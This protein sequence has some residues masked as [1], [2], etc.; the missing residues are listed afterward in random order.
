MEFCPNLNDLMFAKQ[1]RGEPRD[2]GTIVVFVDAGR[3]KAMIKC[4]TEGQVGFLTLDTVRG[5]VQTLETALVEGRIDW[6]PDKKQ[7]RGGVKS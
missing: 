5:L 3:L 6:R 1:V 4:P 7:F 2:P